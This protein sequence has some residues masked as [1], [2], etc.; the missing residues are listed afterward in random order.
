ML[1]GNPQEEEGRRGAGSLGVQ[2]SGPRLMPGPYLHCVVRNHSRLDF[3]LIS[4][5]GWDRSLYS[6][7]KRRPASLGSLSAGCVTTNMPLWPQVWAMLP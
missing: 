3:L 7:C 6:Y 5:A 1:F 2:F 4:A